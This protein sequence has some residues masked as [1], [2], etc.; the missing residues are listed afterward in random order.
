MTILGVYDEGIIEGI[1][2]QYIAVI[3]F[4]LAVMSVL[5]IALNALIAVLSDSY[6]RVQE[7]A[8]ANRR[9]ERAEVR[10]AAFCVCALRKLLTANKPALLLAYRPI[11]VYHAVLVEARYRGTN[12]VLPRVAG[13]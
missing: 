5:V 8:T 10:N 11:L 13:V 7:S 6:A 2:Y 4:V 3:V 1:Q 12:E 9:R